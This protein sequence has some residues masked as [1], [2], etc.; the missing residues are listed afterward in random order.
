MRDQ[1]LRA[2]AIVFIV[3]L[4]LWA[5]LSV[6][7]TN[8]HIL[9]I[10]F[11][12]MKLWP[13]PCLLCCVVYT[14]SFSLIGAPYAVRHFLL[15]APCDNTNGQINSNQSAAYFFEIS[16]ALFFLKFWLRNWG[17]SPYT[18]V[19]LTRAYMVTNNWLL[20]NRKVHYKIFIK[21]RYSKID[22]LSKV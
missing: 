2:N 13:G 5:S 7:T 9:Y 16:L 17:C 14:I 21:V 8:T 18:S 1:M 4:F 6:W 20:H 22:L 12:T 3:Y 19:A 15:A 11:S 10:F